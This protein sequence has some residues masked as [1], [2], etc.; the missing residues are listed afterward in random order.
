[1]LFILF[2]VISLASLTQVYSME[3]GGDR[4]DFNRS[5]QMHREDFNRGNLNRG[6]FNRGGQVNINGGG[7]ENQ[8]PTIVQPY[9]E[10]G[11]PVPNLPQ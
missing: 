5:D 11:E 2:S 4:G 10:P 3:R 7:N 6:D 1:M 8:Q 9:M